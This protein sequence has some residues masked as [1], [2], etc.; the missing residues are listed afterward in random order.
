MVDEPEENKPDSADDAKPWLCMIKDA[1]KV[2][3]PWWNACDS[4]DK[5]FANLARL[6]SATRHR[7]LQV[8]FANVEVMKGVV[9]SREPQPVCVPRFNDSKPLP[10]KASE[11][12]ERVMISS[13]DKEKVHRT[14]IRVRDNLVLHSR[15]VVWARYDA[16]GEGDAFKE[17]VAYDWLHRRDFLHEPARIWSE[18]GWEARGTWLTKEQG[19]KRFGKKWKGIQYEQ[20]AKDTAEGYKYEKKARVWELWHKGK[21]T[22][23]WLHPECDHVLDQKDPWLTLEG[24]FPAP[25]PVYG[26]CEP[27]TLIPVPDFLFVKDQIE[28]VIDLTKRISALTQAVKMRGYYA[29]GAEEV[30]ETIEKLLKDSDDRQVL[31]GISNLAAISGAGLKDSIVWLPIRETVETIKVLIEERR[32]L[33]EDIQEISGISDIMRGQTEASET[34]GAQQLKSQYGSIRVKGKQVEMARLADDLLN[35]A[36]EIMSENFAPKTLLE[37]S[38]MNDLPR[39]ADVQQQIMGIKAQVAAAQQDPAMMQQAQANPEAAQQLLQQAQE[40]VQTLENTVTFEAVVELFQSQRMRPYVLKI[41]TDSTIQPDENAEKAA[42]NEFGQAFAQV[43]A[44]LGPLIQADPGA[45]PFAGDMLKFMLAPFRAG[46]QMDQSIDQFVE[47]AKKK[48]SAPPPPNPEQIKAEQDAAKAK[49]E[50]EEK[51]AERARQEAKEQRDAQLQA[52]KDRRDA[53][54]ADA[55]ARARVAEIQRKAE[56]DAAKHAHEAAMREADFRLKEIELEIAEVKLEQ[57]RVPKQP[58]R[59]LEDA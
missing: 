26:T 3:E 31:I 38:Q 37:M 58:A 4:I 54:I 20:D 14:L 42:R 47:Q 59:E 12:L 52:E 18:V 1:A 39:F 9:Y 21:N 46:R 29:K 56:A 13:F 23:V 36:G 49:M 28:E 10:N 51:Q 41:A 44:S 2:F 7:S 30:G 43:T 50:Q 6:A 57:A 24:F 27:D 5:E 22:V 55:E 15:G 25:E 19:K 40:Q 35:T 45:A 8:F 53:M 16:Q 32:V 17:R 33:L 34:L 11:M 48:A